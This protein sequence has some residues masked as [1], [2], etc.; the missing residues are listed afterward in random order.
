MNTH[1][2]QVHRAQRQQI[3]SPNFESI[4]TCREYRR[5]ALA[6]VPAAKQF[7]AEKCSKE[8]RCNSG[9]CPLCIRALRKRLVEFLHQQNLHDRKWFF[10]TAY[11]R[12]WTRKPGDVR[13]FP[14]L[15][16]HPQIKAFVRR[17]RYLKVPNLMLIG[18]IETVWRT[19]DNK[20]TGKPFHLHFMVSG[21][22]EAQVKQAAS[23]FDRDDNVRTPL[24]VI[25][26]E[27]GWEDF[28]DTATYT[29]KQPFWK[30]SYHGL[31]PKKQRQLPNRQELTELISNLGAHDVRGRFVFV[32]MQY[33]H[34]RFALTP[35]MKSMSAKPKVEDG[36]NN[37]ADAEARP[38]NVVWVNLI[39]GILATLR[40]GNWAPQARLTHQ[41]SIASTA[42]VPPCTA[43]KHNPTERNSDMGAQG[44]RSQS[45]QK[46]S[47]SAKRIFKVKHVEIDEATGNYS[48]ALAVQKKDGVGEIVVAR[49]ALAK[50]SDLKRTLLDKGVLVP[51]NLGDLCAAILDG[52][53]PSREIRVVKTGRWIG[54]AFL[55]PFGVFGK[56]SD[57]ANVRLDRSL[58]LPRKEKGSRNDF[59]SQIRRFLLRSDFLILAYVAAL[60]P[61][62]ASRLGRSS[63]FGLNF[64]GES[65]TGKTTALVLAHSL[66]TEASERSLF[67]F[68]SSP[69]HLTNRL[70]SF[71]GLANPFGDLKAANEKGRQAVEKLQTTIFNAASGKGREGPVTGGLE[72]PSFSIPF[73]SSERPM[74]QLF[75]DGN[76]DYE[77]GDAV[78][79]IDIPVPNRSEGGIYNRRR[80]QESSA[81]LAAELKS[82]LERQHGTIL[83]AWIK[84][85]SSIHT[86]GLDFSRAIS[87]VEFMKFIDEPTDGVH[88]RIADCFCLLYAAGDLASQTGLIPVK[89]VT[90]RRAL[91]RLYDAVLRQFVSASRR[92]EQAWGLFQ[93]GIEKFPL[94]VRGEAPADVAKASTGFR[95]IEKDGLRL[96]VKLEALRTL[97]NDDWCVEHVILKRLI[98]LDA[99]DEGS[100]ARSIHV[101]HKG[102]P[103]TRYLSINLD[104]LD[105]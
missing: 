48:Y 46:T 59:L 50:I 101:K 76:L 88:D 40:A 25:P 100:G 60:L 47:P 8:H 17:L 82:L 7:L 36:S 33:K 32:G 98:E 65:S 27:P 75:Q 77:G 49:S 94:L 91:A 80:A 14:K 92:D 70:T 71:G 86:V 10:V 6:A 21:P 15:G 93:D 78:R 96:Y 81:S 16:S 95:R 103:R 44:T 28:R 73:F 69:V 66:L 84:H 11:I 56:A 12:G 1:P 4:E 42:V 24:K 34:G 61:S 53:L 38:P 3:L 83:P 87:K 99:L 2:S 68:N 104:K 26:V 102:L 37:P 74:A 45:H 29:I 9:L 5:K 57:V 90:I 62:M 52:A 55:C 31:G 79:L 105:P 85:L 18:A 41:P 19:N 43:D 39:E 35:N 97:V 63:S 13:P 72:T 58:V 54:D 64:A 20:A 89:S 22:S 30:Y 67:N 23:G 51:P